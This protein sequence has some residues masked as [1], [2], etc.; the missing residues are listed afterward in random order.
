MKLAS[1]LCGALPRLVTRLGT[2]FTCALLAASCGGIGEGSSPNSS[3]NNPPNMACSSDCGTVFVAI[4]DADGDFLS[5]TVDVVSLKLERANGT[6][7][8]TLPASTRIDF[9]QYVDLTEFLTAATVPNGNYVAATLRLDYSSA[10]ITVEQNGAPV[11]AKAVDDNGAP[12]AVVDV[13]VTLDNRHHLVVAPGRPSLFTLDFN[14]AATNAVDLTTSPATVI[15]TPALVASLELVDQKDLRVRGPLVDVDTASGTYVVDVRPFHGRSERFGRVEV[16]TDSATAFEVNGTS[17]SGSAG[18]DAMDAAGPGIA[19]VALG[20]L[21]T[22]TR[23]FHATQVFAGTSVPGAGIDTV[24]GEVLA[25]SGDELTVRGGT[26]VRNSDGARFARGRVKVLLGPDTKVVKGGSSPAT[27]VD[28]DAISVGQHILAFGAATPVSSTQMSGDWTLDAT[29]GRVRMN[30]TPIYGFVK[31][32]SEGGVTLQLDSIGGRRVSAFDFTGTGMAPE[33]DAD[34][35]NYE[36]ATGALDLSGLHEGEPAKFIGFPTP[37]GAA[38]PDFDARTLVDFPRMG[39]T[40]SMSWGRQG[41]LAPFSSQEEGS[42]V[43]NLDNEDIGRLHF[44]RIGPRW[45]DIT[46]LPASPSIVPPED[47][48]SAYLVVLRDGSKAF[49]EFGDFVEEL[50]KQLDGSKA[51]VAFTATGGY[52]G[53]NNVFTAR[54]IVAVLK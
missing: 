53:H 30:P 49:H 34:P 28:T 52:D 45:V 8:E 29:A 24:M 9:A 22:A 46:T 18:L 35:A 7:V 4:T 33:Q 26:V 23:E 47:G 42:L 41:T 10:E 50:G 27:V 6:T 48:R 31:S 40:L 37:F 43:L 1:L 3:G 54:S 16:H 2:L 25:R 39:A 13:K 19:T 36:V 11:A 15:V 12:L 21:T 14:L 38:P 51:M 44:M 20:T 32:T 5:Y 17:Y